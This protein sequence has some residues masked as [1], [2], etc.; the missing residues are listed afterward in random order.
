MTKKTIISITSIIVVILLLSTAVIAFDIDV[1]KKKESDNIDSYFSKTMEVKE[2]T[3]GDIRNSIS[4]KGSI[5]VENKLKVTMP[6][7][8]KIDEVSVLT[9]SRVNKGDII[10]ILDVKSLEDEYNK[11]YDEW[12]KNKTQL[13]EMKP[14]YDYI[15]IVATHKGKVTENNL[16]KNKTTEDILEDSDSLVTIESDNEKHVYSDNVPRGQISSIGY[17]SRQ[18]K[19]VKSGDMLFIVKV[20]NGGFD[21]QVKKI[22]ELEG[23][24]KAIKGLIDDPTLKA[25][26]D[27][28]ISSVDVTND[29]TC[30]QHKVIA[31]IEPD[32]EFLVSLSITKDEL[33]KVE[34]NQEAN[35]TLDS[36]TELK[37]YVHHISYNANDSGKFNM[38]IK[39][40]NVKNAEPN[41]ILPGLKAGV[42]IVLEEKLEVVKVP[43][44]AIKTDSKGEYVLVY[45]GQMDE[46]NK[47]SVDTVPTEK[48]YIEKGL[49]T[50]MYT[51]IISGVSKGERVVVVTVSKN[52]N[53][54]FGGMIGF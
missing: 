13:G 7:N 53:D 17:G 37:G 2:V 54:N 14:T 29:E 24:L 1:F 8:G 47:Y 20:E 12:T 5:K 23:K 38:T 28:I 25:E 32:N 33:R 6:V 15:R 18:G 50:P 40:K 21:K 44:D 10:A 4:T 41:D 48:R 39:M 45:K 19:T 9:G 31:T 30:E 46:F 3:V 49:V 43:I 34:L 11:I 26:N 16:I 51:E 27:A 36:G 22:E 35:V 52:E 42:E